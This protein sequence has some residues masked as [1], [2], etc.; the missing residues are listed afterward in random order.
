MDEI[1]ET[2]QPVIGQTTFCEKTTQTTPFTVF[3][4]IVTT[5]QLSS[6]TGL[7]SF[8]VLDALS[9]GVKKYIET[10]LV[11]FRMGSLLSLKHQLMLT[12]MKLKLNL[13][14]TTMSL[15]FG[16]HRSTCARYFRRML[17]ILAKLLENFISSP[18]R[19]VIDDNMP[20]HFVNY[21]TTKFV[22]DCT[23]VPVCSPQCI[24][25]R[26]QTYSYYKQRHTLKSLIGCTPSGYVS[27]ISPFF[28]GK[29]SD[30][31]IFNKSN[32]L[33][34]CTEFDAIMVDKGF[35]IREECASHGVTLLQPAFRTGNK[36]FDAAECED[37]RG[38][39]AARV[40]IERV[41]ERLKN[42]KILHDEVQHHYVTD[43]NEIMVCIGGLVNLSPPL[44]GDDS[45]SYCNER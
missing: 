18:T 31:F 36:Q 17:H 8:D 2:E 5:K 22:L 15:L 24:R 26:T 4:N 3:D 42:F 29:A 27:H 1:P 34:Q 25:C 43:M 41:M 12:L 40:N 6:V 33:E 44:L 21:S 37:S 19:Q 16:M 35:P 28:G 32:L 13:T 30:K 38:I 11:G 45:F 23:E 39:A 14:F 7:C 10:Y 9:S 20:S